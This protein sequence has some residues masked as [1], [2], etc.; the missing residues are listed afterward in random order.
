MQPFVPLAERV[1]DALLDSDPLLAHYTGDHRGDQR[2]PDWSSDSTRAQ[3]T[4]LREASNALAELDTEFL[5]PEEAVDY[6]L[7]TGLVDRR[8]FEL[9]EI[10]GYEWNPLA[11]NPG[12]LLHGLLKRSSRLPRSVTP[13]TRELR[14]PPAPAAE[15]LESLTA[16][17]ELIPDA[18]AVAAGVL[19][20]C[21]AIHLET[22]TGQFAG[23]A[24]LIRD[25][26]PALASE[27][28]VAD[29]RLDAA[30]QRAL[31]ALG[32]F[33]GWLRRQLESG[34]PG[35]D[36]RLGRPLWEARL[37]HTL[38]SELSASELAD[39]AWANLDRVT[40]QIRL[41]AA[42]LTGGS[43]DDATVRAALA[44]IAE[45]RPDDA[46]IVG[47]AGDALAETTLFVTAHDLVSLVD[48]PCEIVVMPEFA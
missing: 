11:H 3:I 9:E 34:D 4:M 24:A 1:I 14:R 10:R 15:R 29:W 30:R 35:R 37:W 45:D 38:D 32:E 7:L 25:E 17:L 5:T 12:P 43:P 21:P 31:A 33:D 26:V 40:E 18:L 8:L 36:P 46:T 41:A 6:A 22:A 19:D 47:R 23:V 2:L 16:R 42:E 13:G 48:D 27:A 39:R 20:E 44:Q 28:R